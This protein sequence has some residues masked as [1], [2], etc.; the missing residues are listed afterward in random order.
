MI[1][2]TV[3]SLLALTSAVYALDSKEIEVVRKYD[4]SNAKPC[5][6]TPDNTFICY[7]HIGDTLFEL[8]LLGD[9]TGSAEEDGSGLQK[10]PLIAS[11]INS[12]EVF[13]DFIKDTYGA[14]AAAEAD[15]RI[16]VGGTISGLSNHGSTDCQHN[17]TNGAIQRAMRHT[18]N[19]IY[20]FV[21][22]AGVDTAVNGLGQLVN[23][24][25]SY[26]KVNQAPTSKCM[27][28]DDNNN[29]VSWAQYGD[30]G[31]VGNESPYISQFTVACGQRGRCS[32][33][34]KRMSDGGEVSG[35]VWITAMK[36]CANPNS[37]SLKFKKTGATS[38]RW[39]LKRRTLY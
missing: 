35:S 2:K 26:L 20:K 15:K 38:G 21:H 17:S 1:P 6:V 34:K 31:I 13:I 37:Y 8:E 29:C 32:I 24:G 12:T 25:I 39:F 11:S 3:I 30:I 22:A 36:R 27:K 16:R 18:I 4:L 10:K 23:K 5:A 7:N 33:L 9:L 28:L 19:S 14:N